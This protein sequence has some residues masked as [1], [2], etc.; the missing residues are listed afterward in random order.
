MCAKYNLT[1]GGP[2]QLVHLFLSKVIAP[3]MCFKP[4]HLCPFHFYQI[5]CPPSF[6]KWLKT[7]KESLPL[8]S[9]LHLTSCILSSQF[10]SLPLLCRPASMW[11]I[12]TNFQ[13]HQFHPSHA[14]F[15]LPPTSHKSGPSSLHSSNFDSWALSREFSL[16]LMNSCPASLITTSKPPGLC[17]PPAADAS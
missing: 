4:R 16:P 10:F 15:H 2:S 12:P 13:H 14:P 17:C 9:S 7:P 1:L 5:A 8:F 11:R 3:I 6:V